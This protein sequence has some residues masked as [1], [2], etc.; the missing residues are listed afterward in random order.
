MTPKRQY[1][2]HMYLAVSALKAA[3]RPAGGFEN[4]GGGETEEPIA[5]IAG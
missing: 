3:M 1:H 4:P 2:D 5:P